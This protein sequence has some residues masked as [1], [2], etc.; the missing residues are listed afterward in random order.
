MNT[1]WLPDWW[2]S[3]QVGWS[4]SYLLGSKEKKGCVIVT[5]RYVLN[6][7]LKQNPKHYVKRNVKPHPGGE[8]QTPWA[9]EHDVSGAQN[10]VL[11]Q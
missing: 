9:E 8:Q 1:S 6:Q 3:F 11:Y 10:S 2:F 7:A 4:Y 5:H